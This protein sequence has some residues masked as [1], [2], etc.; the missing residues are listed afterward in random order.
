[1]QGQSCV[2]CGSVAARLA[3]GSAGGC[4]LCKAVLYCS[5]Q[6]VFRCNTVALCHES[7]CQ[8]ASLVE[9]CSSPRQKY[10]R[11][12]HGAGSWEAHEQAVFVAHAHSSMQKLWPRMGELRQLLVPAKALR[13]HAVQD[14]VQGA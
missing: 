12:G 2:A 7:S 8:A 1:M 9:Q 11:E 6:P 3:A 13:L 4:K 5:W 14:Q 10:T